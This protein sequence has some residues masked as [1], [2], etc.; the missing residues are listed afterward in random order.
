M[1]KPKK[2]KLCPSTKKNSIPQHLKAM[3]DSSMKKK[4]K[5]CCQQWLLKCLA[6]YFLGSG[7]IIL[8]VAHFGEVNVR[9]LIWPRYIRS[10]K[11]NREHISDVF[12][13]DGKTNFCYRSF[14]TNPL[15]L[16][17]YIYSSTQQTVT[18][19]DLDA[20][21][22]GAYLLD[23]FKPHKN[24]HFDVFFCRTLELLLAGKSVLDLGAAIGQ[25]G[26]CLMRI[27]KPMFPDTPE[28]DEFFWG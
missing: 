10:G 22:H 16:V 4:L 17:L 19:A 25:Y 3:F 12:Q 27:D 1:V 11:Q 21:E 7:I 24:H 8:M 26:R 6:L 23:P 28:V 18:T 5:I 13:N 20:V 9:Q 14:E 2:Q 15:C